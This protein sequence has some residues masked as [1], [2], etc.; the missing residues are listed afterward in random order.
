MPT[1]T[2][3]ETGGGQPA[4]LVTSSGDGQ[5]GR[6]RRLVRSRQ[7]NA[8]VGMSAEEGSPSTSDVSA[9]GNQPTG[10]EPCRCKRRGCMTCP[11]LS[12]SNE[13]VSNVTKKP[14][15]T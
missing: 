4:P 11:K 14:L 6:P 9:N 8:V 10:R 7:G 5:N 2:R 1:S 15:K 3:S 12:T 13:F